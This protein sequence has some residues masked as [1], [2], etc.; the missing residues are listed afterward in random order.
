MLMEEVVPQAK[1]YRTVG[2]YS[3]QGKKGGGRA[4]KRHLPLEDHQA[5]TMPNSRGVGQGM[6]YSLRLQQCKFEDSSP[7]LSGLIKRN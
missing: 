2:G 7:P 4:K 1:H 5:L 3:D 6:G